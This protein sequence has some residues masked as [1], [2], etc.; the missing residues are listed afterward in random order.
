MSL[1][2]V[3]SGCGSSAPHSS[4]ATP[5][6]E[7]ARSSSGPVSAQGGPEARAMVGR[8]GGTLTLSNGARLS[9]PADALS[10]EVEVTLHVG[11]D[12]RAF[13]DRERQRPLGP[14]LAVEPAIVSNGD[15]IEL[16]IP[17]LALPGGYSEDDLAF[18]VE[19]P[20]EE[21]TMGT[22]ATETR[23]QFLPVQIQNGRFVARTDGLPGQRLQFGVAR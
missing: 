8:A 1:A 4:S 20:T 7:V 12:G 23:W 22:L 5:R 10:E 3:L 6:I 17:Q 2:L 21:R 11:A 14:M 19:E 9:I 13:G 18:A 15:A 16:S